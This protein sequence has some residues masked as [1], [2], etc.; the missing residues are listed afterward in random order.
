[1]KYEQTQRKGLLQEEIDKKKSANNV[2]EYVIYNKLIIVK[3][4]YQ[5]HDRK[6]LILNFS[7]TSNMVH[8]EE[9]MT[10]SRTPKH[11]SP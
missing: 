3:K 7:A 9:N 1:M 4:L 8:L 10:T 11:E 5:D 2:T 6:T